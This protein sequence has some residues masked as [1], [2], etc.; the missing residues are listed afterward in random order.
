MKIL[1]G[2]HLFSALGTHICD[3]KG[4]AI[5]ATE[6]VECDIIPEHFD[7]VKSIIETERSIKGLDAEGKPIIEVTP[8]LPQDE[9]P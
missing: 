7:R 9:A 6:D 5:K 1:K 2:E 4:V 3:A 8:D